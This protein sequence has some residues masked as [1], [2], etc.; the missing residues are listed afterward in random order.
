M[1]AAALIS[2]SGGQATASESSGTEQQA[3]TVAFNADSAM[4]LVRQQCDFGPRVPGTA[5]HKQCAA[6]LE[7]Q[8]RR[9]CDQV[10]VQRPTLTTFDG[11]R[12]EAAN[13]VG[14]INPDAPQR[15]LLMAHWDSRP[16]ADNDPDSGKRRE[17]VMGANDGASGVAVLLEL[18]R[19]FGASK[20]AVGIDIVLTD[21]ED[22]GTD[23]NEDSWALGT[24]YWVQHPHRDGYKPM[25]GILVDMVGAPDAKFYA[26]GF[27]QQAAPQLVSA[28]WQSAHDA[29]YGH[30]FPTRVGGFVT[31]D[32]VPVIKAGIPCIDIIDL[33]PGQGSGFVGTWHTTADTPD[34]ISPAT[35]KAVGQTLAEFISTLDI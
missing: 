28:V 16:W 32:H 23:D 14:V 21:V 9:H 25:Y 11:T 20:P 15:L 7:Q 12:L 5:A 8:L 10:V 17:P 13:L 18:A 35:L 19:L 22:W 26:E 33:R 29:G 34:N 3:A 31:D 24:Q 6:L 30:L 27:S 1:A 2:C 4:A